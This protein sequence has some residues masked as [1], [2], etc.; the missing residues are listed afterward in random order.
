MTDYVLASGIF[1]VKNNV[2]SK[3]WKT[4]VFNTIIKMFKFSKK[5]IA[6][7]LMTFDVT[8]KNKLF[9]YMSV[10]EIL[11]FLRK[12]ISKK[13]TINHSYNLWEYTVFVYK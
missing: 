7:N 4:H 2:S 11:R 9:F 13:I 10:D 12:K 1:S 5:G 3:A 6:F 8:F